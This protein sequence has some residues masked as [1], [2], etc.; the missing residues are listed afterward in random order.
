MRWREQQS[1]KE[2][3]ELERLHAVR[4]DLRDQ[5]TALELEHQA[6]RSHL[7]PDSSLASHELLALATYVSAL[8]T[9]SAQI[10]DDETACDAN[11]AEQRT[12]CIDA[13]R[14]VRVFEKLK[15]KR[16]VEWER[17]L[18]RE[19]EETATTSFLSTWSRELR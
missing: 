4:S 14:Q 7:D 8:Q 18:H 5:R 15:E 12:K 2:R 17:E 13:D 1:E 6:M 19:V 11:I 9:R 10:R 3:N 16:R